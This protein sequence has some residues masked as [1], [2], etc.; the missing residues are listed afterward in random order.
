M[1]ARIVRMAVFALSITGLAFALP[2]G[3]DH[4]V[5]QKSKGKGRGTNKAPA[6]LPAGD[7]IAMSLEVEVLRSLYGMEVTP[8]QAAALG[9]F[10]SE[11]CDKPRIRKPAKA[12]DK[13]R[14]ALADFRKA[15]TDGQPDKIDEMEDKLEDARAADSPDLDDDFDIT[16]A[17][18]RRAP[19]ALRLL[20][21]RQVV[22]YAADEGDDITD[23]YERLR[24][25]IK[26]AR[27]VKADDWPALRDETAG[28]VGEAVGGV[29]AEKVASVTKEA[30]ALLDRARGL[31]PTELTSLA[32][33]LEKAAR[34][35]VGTIGPMDVL[36]HALELHLARQL[37]N[38]QAATAFAALAAKTK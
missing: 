5:S 8:A 34:A 31:S 26:D 27:T 35:V 37:S 38:P 13:F 22:A 12:S 15:L 28:A 36:Q 4:G 7:V 19:E 16:P 21:V 33:E 25:A 2:P 10:A 24:D 6:P 20:S 23:P 14:R 11:T 29:D 17:A 32:V 3:P 9:K 1:T 30:A 18:R